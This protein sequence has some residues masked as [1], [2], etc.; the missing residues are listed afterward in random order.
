MVG[1]TNKQTPDIELISH[2][3]IFVELNIFFE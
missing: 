1:Q 2:T 3:C